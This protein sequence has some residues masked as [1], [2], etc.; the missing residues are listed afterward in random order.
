MK[1]VLTCADVILQ[2]AAFV[3]ET[4]EQGQPYEALLHYNMSAGVI[5]TQV[6]VTFHLFIANYV[7]LARFRDIDRSG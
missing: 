2:E 3:T 7:T 6:V 5:Y 1:F 4:F